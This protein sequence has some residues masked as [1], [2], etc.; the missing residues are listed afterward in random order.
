MNKDAKIITAI[1]K[2]PLTKKEKNK[3]QIDIIDIKSATS[4]VLK[5]EKQ[6]VDLTQYTE[7]H[8]F[9]FD[10]CYDQDVHNTDLYSDLVQPLVASA[11]SKARITV[12]AYGQTGSG[13]TYTMGTLEAIKT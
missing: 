7:E 12:F 2:R 9:H 8:T 11:F 6:K 5:E 3:K 1:R 4:L 10:G 13:K